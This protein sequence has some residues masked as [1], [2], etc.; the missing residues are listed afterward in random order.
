MVIVEDGDPRILLKLKNS[1]VGNLL[2]KCN[3][4]GY[5]YMNQADNLYT[6]RK[7]KVKK[8]LW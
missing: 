3:M 6:P 2:Q 7:I 8:D 1:E 4:E 5:I